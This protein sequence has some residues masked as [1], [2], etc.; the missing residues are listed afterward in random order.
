VDGSGWQGI[1]VPAGTPR[2]VIEKLS[3][4]VA[5]AI[6]DP[7]VR[8]RFGS[9][10]LDP[11]SMTGDEFSAHIRTEVPKWKAIARKANIKVE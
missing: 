10:G 2:A 9:Q 8:E 7:E 11:A 4:A 3:A 1:V 6:A 5:K